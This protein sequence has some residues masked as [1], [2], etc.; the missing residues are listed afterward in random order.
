MSMTPKY[1][2]III[3]ITIILLMKILYIEIPSDLLIHSKLTFKQKQ[4]INKQ[5]KPHKRRFQKPDVV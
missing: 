1:I 3:I 4:W 2:H 5:I